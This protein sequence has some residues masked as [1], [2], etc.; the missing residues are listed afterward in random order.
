MPDT[1]TITDNRTGKQYEIPITDDTIKAIDLRQIKVNPE[2]F[3][4]MTFDPAFLNTASCR[5]AV[6]FI[7]GSKGILRYR[8]YPIEQ[9]AEKST[10]VETAYLLV[11][12][13]LPTHEEL[14]TW[15]GDLS[16]HVM[17]HENIK[18]FM[19]GFRYDAHPMGIFLST[20]GALSTFYPLAKDIDDPASRRRQTLRL[21]A[22][23]PSIAAYA[24]RHSVGKPYV[25][26]DSE[27]SY[28][29]N[30]LNQ[31]FKR[32][33]PFYRP[34]PVLERALDVLF[35]LHA[36]H[37]QNC[38]TSAMRNIGSSNADP[39]VSLAGAAA[40]LYG[41]L[42]GGANEAVLRMLDKIGTVDNVPKFV[43][44]V[45]NGEGRLMGFGHRVYK[46]YDPR[47]K[48]IKAT[49]D[50]VFEVTGRN[51]LLDVAL[52]LERI[53]LED[54]YF[55]SRKLYPNVD[56]YSGLIYQAMGFDPAMF[57]VLFAIGRTAGWI[58][59][60]QELVSDSSRK[61]ARPRQIYTGSDTRDFVQID[62]RS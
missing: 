2:D 7:D 44:S 60:W 47:A 12:G 27:L 28:T 56:F 50:Q 51:P 22:K 11:Y 55:V 8:G 19:E 42:H 26:P 33:E 6:T 54:D 3:G 25:Y 16:D 48:V 13:E 9:L 37:E 41:P 40:A 10:F 17:L 34:D 45:K 30:F 57:P 46:S 18:K 21:I 39:Y 24:Y 43:E 36:D 29:G 5:S 4:M 23:V 1:L 58:A 32:T 62:A 15:K 52:E 31:L 61:I 53:A 59:Q 35:I 20:V 49:A 14:A 38:S